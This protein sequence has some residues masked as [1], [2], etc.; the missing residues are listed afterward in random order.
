[1]NHPFQTYWV[2]CARA[3]EEIAPAI[4]E[5]TGWGVWNPA[6]YGAHWHAARLEAYP[7]EPHPIVMSGLNPG[8]YGMTQTGIPFTDMK[9]VRSDLPKIAARLAAEGATLEVPGLAP[10]DLQTYLV[11]KH[12]QSAARFYAFFRAAYGSAE[13]ALTHVV[14]VNSCMLLFIDT[15]TGKN[16]TPAD[17]K[18]ALIRKRHPD[19]SLERMKAL[20]DEVSAL[21]IQWVGKAM[22]ILE[23]RAVVLLG[24]NAQAVMGGGHLPATCPEIHYPHPARKGPEWEAGLI[25][26]LHNYL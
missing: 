8:P 5:A 9:R 19:W 1:M 17:L 15:A 2:E 10:A 26:A 21:R 24:Q 18:P 16:V 12:E 6:L 4:R 22:E 13:D 25:E 11:L 20:C 7:P 14:N 3:W 23:P